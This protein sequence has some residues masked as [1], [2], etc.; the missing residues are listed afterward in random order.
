MK[1]FPLTLAAIL[2]IFS[3]GLVNSSWGRSFAGMHGG[4][5]HGGGFGG[6][7]MRGGGGGLPGGLGSGGNF[8]GARPGGNFGGGNFGGAC[9]LG[10]DRF[11][12]GG[13][14]RFGRR[15]PGKGGF[16]GGAGGFDKR[17]DRKQLGSFLVLPSDAGMNKVSANDVRLGNTQIGG[18]AVNRNRVGSY[19]IDRNQ[20]G[21]TDLDRNRLGIDDR[22]LTRYSGAELRLRGDYVRRDF[23]GRNY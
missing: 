22:G 5:M 11:P 8:G 4:G 20:I 1:K 7:G 14:G 9:G 2:S 17:S 23:D 18:N 19:R 12:D 16:T 13:A 10:G 3:I 21:R 15:E 6:G